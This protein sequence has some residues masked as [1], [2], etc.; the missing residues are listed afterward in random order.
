MIFKMMV[1]SL[2]A[3]NFAEALAF[4]ILEKEVVTWEFLSNSALFDVGWCQ[5]IIQ[6]KT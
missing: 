6:T 2:T 4:Q 1:Y 3:P 5:A